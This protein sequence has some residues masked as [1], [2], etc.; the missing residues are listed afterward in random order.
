M[1]KFI[2]ALILF[3]YIVHAE[4]LADYTVRKCVYLILDSDAKFNNFNDFDSEKILNC[5]NLYEKLGGDIKAINYNYH[6]ISQIAL[7]YQTICRGK[8]KLTSE[9]KY[10]DEE[11]SKICEGLAYSVSVSIMQDKYYCINNK[12]DIPCR[13]MPE[14]YY[15]IIEELK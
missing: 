2:F 12:E 6:I 1:K 13:Y 4:T 11:I 5:F 9:K 10:T 7:D 14:K 8:I 3:P 15:Q